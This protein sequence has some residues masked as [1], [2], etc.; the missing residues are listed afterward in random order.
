MEEEI[1][2]SMSPRDKEA[3]KTLISSKENSLSGQFATAE[4]LQLN[5]ETMGSC[6]PKVG[7]EMN[8]P[9]NLL[10]GNRVLKDRA[11]YTLKTFNGTL[12]I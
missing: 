9:L 8:R 6:I 12:N 4:V 11:K 2:R 5:S 3:F 1:V 10:Y 7:T